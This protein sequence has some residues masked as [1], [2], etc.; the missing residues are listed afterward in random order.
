MRRPWRPTVDAL[1]P[2]L[3]LLWRRDPSV[4]ITAAY[5]WQ[6]EVFGLSESPLSSCLVPIDP[7]RLPASETKQSMELKAERE[8]KQL[9]ILR[10]L[11]Q[12][13]P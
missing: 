7:S 2:W 10:H 5:L 1:V 13:A 11:V 12:W 6:V 8:G 4:E 3:V 9:I